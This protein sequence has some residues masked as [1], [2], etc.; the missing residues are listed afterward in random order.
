VLSSGGL[1]DGPITWVEGRAE[2]DASE[3]DRGS[4]QRW[5]WP[6]VASEPRKEKFMTLSVGYCCVNSVP[7]QEFS[8][9]AHYKDVS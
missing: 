3:C 7:L 8:T 2:C 5:P 6:T 9:E 1:C 4:S